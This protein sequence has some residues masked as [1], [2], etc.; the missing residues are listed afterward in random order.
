MNVEGY[1]Q[2]PFEIGDIIREKEDGTTACITYANYAYVYF[3][4]LTAGWN[5]YPEHVGTE[6]CTRIERLEEEWEKVDQQGKQ[7]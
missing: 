3:K 2:I 7:P 1:G 4:I 5:T 6:L